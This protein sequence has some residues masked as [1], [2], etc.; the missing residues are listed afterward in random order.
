VDIYG[1]S[2]LVT[3]VKQQLQILQTTLPWIVAL[4]V[5]AEALY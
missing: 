3:D 5:G 1:Q 2:V 4:F